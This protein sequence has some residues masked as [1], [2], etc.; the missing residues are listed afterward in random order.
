MK[1]A[2]GLR[3]LKV[4]FF[5]Y[6]AP[7]MT[8][9]QPVN[10]NPCGATELTVVQTADPC[11]PTM[12]T[13]TNPTFL[14][15]ALPDPGTCPGPVTLPSYPDY[16]FKFTA[17]TTSARLNFTP[18]SGTT[19]GGGIFGTGANYF[20]VYKATN[21]NGPFTLTKGCGRTD[22]LYT[23]LLSN[24]EVSGVY[25]IRVVS[26]LSNVATSNFGICVSTNMPPTTA[27]V[28]INVSQPATNVDVAGN[29]QFRNDVNFQGRITYYGPGEFSQSGLADSV[30]GRSTLLRFSD[31]QGKKIIL[32]NGLYFDQSYPGNTVGQGAIG[33][34]V[35]TLQ[36]Q[37]PSQ[38]GGGLQFGYGN[39]V[40]SFTQT[41]MISGT[42][43]LAVNGGGTFGGNVGIGL[44]G[45][46][47]R[48]SIST[49]GGQLGGS[50]MSS[51]FKV[52]AGNLGTSVGDELSIASL[53]FMG[54]TN[55][56]SLGIRGY[57]HTNG[58]DWFGTT[59]LLGYD[60]DNTVRAGAGSYLAISANGNIG[61]ANSK[62]LRPLSFPATLGEKIL[63]YPGVNGEVGIGVYGNELRLHSD[64]PGAKVSFGTQDNAGVFTEVGKFEKNGAYGLS[65]FGSIWANGITY[66]S[67]GRFK[68]DVAPLN[69]SLEKVLQLQGVS[70]QMKTDE[71]P[72][73]HFDSAVQLGLVAQDVEKV[74]PEVVTTGPDGFKA[75]DYAKLVPLLIESIKQQQAEIEKL[76][77]MAGIKR[78]DK[79]KG[80]VYQ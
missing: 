43:H 21:C 44:T 61:I 66:A 27:K 78:K 30:N 67:D 31:G 29:V 52:N 20:V 64:N 13:M 28:G 2:V 71:F 12:Y 3:W 51:A 22:I 60:V 59:L 68:K 16:W 11:T 24:L 5:L 56:I 62:P 40:S 35:G 10:D 76:K 7:W 58:N 45:P 33:V 38:N 4:A 19:T 74:V 79:R 8:V 80:S 1:R 34:G 9:A 70:Y 57:R 46:T 17:T 23:I 77:K 37:Y 26:A 25:Y 39:G 49:T 14:N 6:L 18:E 53:G 63:L 41:A 36:I 72:Q 65:V 32:G 69:N 75:I 50:A 54:G 55:N 15:L 47:A 42:G 73:E 48:L